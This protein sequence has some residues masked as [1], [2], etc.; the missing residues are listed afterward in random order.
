MLLGDSDHHAEHD[1]QRVE[2]Q[3]TS[4][5]AA[6]TSQS[7]SFSAATVGNTSRGG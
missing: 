1:T 2:Q 3:M 7:L 6:Q 4:G 5:K